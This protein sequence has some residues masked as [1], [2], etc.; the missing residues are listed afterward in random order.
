MYLVTLHAFFTYM[1]QHTNLTIRHLKLCY[2]SI[3]TN[4]ATTANEYKSII[5]LY[6]A[7]L[8]KKKDKNDNN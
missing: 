5:K 6:T 4:L 8:T 3:F 2:I 1:S 7:T